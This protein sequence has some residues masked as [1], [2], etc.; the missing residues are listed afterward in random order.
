MLD[1]GLYRTSRAE[2]HEPRLEETLLI[3]KYIVYLARFSS[4]ATLPRLQ[5]LKTNTHQSSF[6]PQTEATWASSQFD[7]L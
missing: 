5:T 7:L 4:I 3:V 1:I 2:G 6:A